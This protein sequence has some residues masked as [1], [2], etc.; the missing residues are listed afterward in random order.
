MIYCAK[1]YRDHYVLV[2]D[3]LSDPSEISLRRGREELI[4]CLPEYPDPV[5]LAVCSE[6]RCASVLLSSGEPLELYVSEP[7]EL[8]ILEEDERRNWKK[9]QRWWVTNAISIINKK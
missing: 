5:I 8:E 6:D 9:I 3:Y 7:G 1:F 2:F 4:Y